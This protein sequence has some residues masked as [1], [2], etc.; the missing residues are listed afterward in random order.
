MKNLKYLVPK[1]HTFMIDEENP[2]MIT[3]QDLNHISR[4][5]VLVYTL[6]KAVMDGLRKSPSL[7]SGVLFGG[8]DKDYQTLGMMHPERYPLLTRVDLMVD[9]EGNWKIAEIDPSNKHATGFSLATR[10]ESGAGE[11]QKFLPLLAPHITEDVTIV[12]ARKETFFRYEQRFFAEKL[13]EH[14]GKKVIVVPEDNLKTLD[15]T[16]LILDFPFCDEMCRELLGRRFQEQPES[17][18]NPPR[19]HLGGKALMTLP[20]EYEK[21]LESA[22]MN[23]LEIQELKTYLPPTYSGPFVAKEVFSS[24]AKGVNFDSIGKHTVF[25]KYVEQR[26][27]GMNGEKKFIRLACFYVGSALAELIVAATT[28]LPVHGGEGAVNYHVNLRE[29]G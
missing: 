25:Q 7:V 23:Q 5:G 26:P 9:V 13:A 20:W 18:V 19:H 4:V 12:L 16:G 24:G 29:E 14:T 21:W 3:R 6:M 10:L 8:L 15:G 17:F 28:Q 27:F 22:G 1:G 2:H 11:R